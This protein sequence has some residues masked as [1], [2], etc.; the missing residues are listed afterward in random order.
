MERHFLR[1]LKDSLPLSSSG[2]PGLVWL[3]HHP[4]GLLRATGCSELE[5]SPVAE[6]KEG[7]SSPDSC[8]TKP[9]LK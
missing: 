2:L 7:T 1:L 5:A 3:F 9:L 6:Q 4:G 8:W